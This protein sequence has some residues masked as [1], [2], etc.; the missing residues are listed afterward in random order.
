MCYNVFMTT[1][2]LQRRT[3][4]GPTERSPTPNATYSDTTTLQNVVPTVLGNGH[5]NTLI[6]AFPRPD[7]DKVTLASLVHANSCLVSTDLATMGAGPAIA[8][9]PPSRNHMDHGTR[10]IHAIA[11]GALACLVEYPYR[12]QGYAKDPEVTQLQNDRP[13]R[14]ASDVLA[15]LALNAPDN[16]NSLV[17]D[18]L[19]RY[20]QYRGSGPHNILSSSGF[21]NVIAVPLKRLPSPSRLR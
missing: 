11:K 16:P 14:T 15:I 6:M 1:V 9:G 20:Q 8:I 12:L 5:N 19:N 4:T 13:Y 10:S 18:I 17:E 3:V 2:T 7:T 21:P